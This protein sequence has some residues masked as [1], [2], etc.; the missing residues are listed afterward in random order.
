LE[1]LNNAR[2]SASE[3]VMARW[4][5]ARR[6][7]LSAHFAALLAFAI[8]FFLIAVHLRPWSRRDPSSVFFEPLSAFEP[9]YSVLRTQQAIDYVDAVSANPQKYA[10]PVSKS[11]QFAIGIGTVEREETQYVK[12]AVG[13][14]LHGLTKEERDQFHLTFFIAHT[15]PNLHS[16]FNESWFHTLA[17][18]IMTY[19][20]APAD[21]LD[22]ATWYETNDPYHQV[23]PL[24]D[25]SKLLQDGYDLGVP[26]VLVLEDDVLAM[27]GWLHRTLAAL[28]QLS[29][30][31]KDR[32]LT[33]YIR[34]FYNERIQGW[35][36]ENWSTYLY[37]SILAAAIT[38]FV[39]VVLRRSPGMARFLNGPT[40]LFILLVIL[41]GC[42]GF[43]F[44]SGRL[45]V[46]PL[47]H[48]LQHME[49]YG[50]CSQ[51]LIFP[52]ESIPGLIQYYRDVQQGWVDS[53][54]E[55]YADETGL[56]RLALVPS[57]FQHIGGSSSKGG[58]KKPITRW[59]RTSPQNIWNFGFE[60]MDPSKLRK[61]HEGHVK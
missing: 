37:R 41:P 53:L 3:I 25:Y 60:L 7:Q 6:G 54:M 61:E 56:Q 30:H 43:F 8:I 51:A 19:P 14:L 28:K 39:I 52:R 32:A 29:S 11:P 57:V 13:S 31:P 18:R 20:D 36:S 24:L 34:L 10:R 55:S 35:N 46:A 58:N 33:L 49:K 1:R 17:D 40:V 48:G 22:R 26:Y 42:I 47:R 16:A 2:G 59:G 4:V 21:V 9:Q 50:C 44:A 23:K 38:T 12:A 5:G 27:D 15:N 45:T